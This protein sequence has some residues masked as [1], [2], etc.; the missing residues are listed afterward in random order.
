MYDYLVIISVFDN[1]AASQ[2]YSALISD[3]HVP[4]KKIVWPFE[5]HAIAALALNPLIEP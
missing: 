2:V 4:E 1:R 3:Y 5:T